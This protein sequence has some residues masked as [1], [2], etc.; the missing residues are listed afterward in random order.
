MLWFASA[1]FAAAAAT[2]PTKI[3]VAI[4][5]RAPFHH[6]VYPAMHHAWERAGY[7]ATSYVEGGW[8]TRMTDVTTSW[9]FQFKNITRFPS[10]FCKYK[11]IIF[12][13]VEYSWDYR[14]ASRMVSTACGGL[15]KYVFVVHNPGSL[16]D[17]RRGLSKLLPL[18]TANKNVFVVGLSPH[19]TEAINTILQPHNIQAEYL[20]PL[21]PID[22]SAADVSP[23]TGFALQGSI[24]DRRRNYKKLIDIIVTEQSKLPHNFQLSVLGHG[25]MSIPT[26]AGGFVELWKDLAYPKYYQTIQRSLGL[27]TA[28]ASKVYFREKSSSTVAASLICGAPLLTETA[29]LNVYSY[30]SASSVWL[31]RSGEDD[32]DAM[33]RILAMDNLEEEYLKRYKSLQGD[34]ERAHVHNT[35]TIDKIMSHLLGVS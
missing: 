17:G 13:S 6:E 20:I 11:V 28:F 16:R 27:L 19:T 5:N 31:R 2:A 26:E 24:S 22:L 32:V 4:I 35:V 14:M 33:L 15:T 12:S 8:D 10:R 9:G 21:F 1:R 23:H 3:Q 29:T 7:I 18:I 25:N 30:L 34:I